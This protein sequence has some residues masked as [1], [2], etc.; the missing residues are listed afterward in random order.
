MLQF[1]IF[2]AYTCAS[3]YTPTK[4]SNKALKHYSFSRFCSGKGCMMEKSIL[5]QEPR[6]SFFG[7]IKREEELDESTFNVWKSELQKE[8][9]VFWE[10]M[11]SKRLK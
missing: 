11:N 7:I 1:W 4:N 8:L 6:T 9:P 2:L 10:E 3:T 5:I